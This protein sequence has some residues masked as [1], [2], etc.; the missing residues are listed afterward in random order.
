MTTAKSTR[1]RRRRRFR[2]ALV[3]AAASACR[4]R[5]PLLSDVDT[6][7]RV[8]LPVGIKRRVNGGPDRLKLNIFEKMYVN[9]PAHTISQIRN[10][11]FL[12]KLH[13]LPAGSRVVEIGCGRGVGMQLILRVFE[14]ASAEALDIDPKMIRLTQQRLHAVPSERVKV[15]LADVHRL[16]YP[17]GSIDAVFDFGVL[18]HLEE[19]RTGLAEV[20]RVLPEGGHFY[21]EEYFP[22]LYANAFFGRLLAHPTEDRFHAEEFKNAL[23]EERLTMLAG[24]AESKF[25]LL[26]VA[27]KKR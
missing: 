26:G 4:I 12:R 14:P 10:V 27:V 18:H 23:A 15:Q 6:I 11:S 16:P 8:G 19:W 22:A 7:E 1:L 13:A 9:S 2:G 17:D 20:A 24:Y 3:V 5:A 21:I 25:R